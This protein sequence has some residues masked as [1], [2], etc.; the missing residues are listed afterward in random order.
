MGKTFSGRFSPGFGHSIRQQPCYKNCLLE[1]DIYDMNLWQFFKGKELSNPPVPVLISHR[2][3]MFDMI[4]DGLRHIQNHG[5]FHLDIKLSNILINKNQ[6][7]WDRKT[8]VITDFGIGG[9]D[10]KRLGKSGTP[11]CAS[12]EQLIGKVH[13]KSDNFGLGRLMSFIFFKWHTAWEVQCQPLK[14]ADYESI[15]NKIDPTSAE[16]FLFEIIQDLTQVMGHLFYNN[17]PCK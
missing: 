15:I 7:E 5:Y 3:E 1:M 8:L 6:D 9:K 2:F 10:L 12:P 16:Y 14:T 13:A 11:G 4:L 17:L